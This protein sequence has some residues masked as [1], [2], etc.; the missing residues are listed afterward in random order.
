[1]KKVVIVLAAL[2][3]IGLGAST[4]L[5]IRKSAVELGAAS[6][7]Q[8]AAAAIAALDANDTNATL[9]LLVG[10][11][12]DELAADCDEARA[13]ND[14][15][16]AKRVADGLAQSRPPG[17]VIDHM[18]SDQSDVLHEKGAAI[19][20]HCKARAT[21]V[22]H[23]TTLALHDSAGKAWTAELVAM[24][25]G[26]RWFLAQVPV[27]TPPQAAA[28]LATPDI[29]EPGELTGA[30]AQMWQIAGALRNCAEASVAMTDHIRNMEISIG[31]QRRLGHD[32]YFT[33]ADCIGEIKR[34]TREFPSCKTDN[35]PQPVVA[36]LGMSRNKLMIKAFDALDAKDAAA[37]HA[38]FADAPACANVADVDKRIAD[39]IAASIKTLEFERIRKDE[40]SEACPGVTRHAMKLV[41]HM[42]DGTVYGADMVELQS[43]GRWWLAEL[44]IAKPTP[45]SHPAEFAGKRP[46]ETE[47]VLAESSF[48]PGELSP[49]CAAMWKRALA[50]RSCERVVLAKSVAVDA[51]GFFLKAID[52]AKVSDADCRDA[53]KIY[54]TDFANCR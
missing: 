8:L 53:L 18:G 14:E 6:R 10:P 19:S 54:D 20:P 43:G 40:T 37:L 3:A 51:Y 23:A 47:L 16:R 45:P 13:T 52:H 28:K 39:A 5:L 7:D 17:L 11:A 12:S 44:P 15:A 35:L 31:R 41:F 22:R 21:I 32:P 29:F 48:A 24:E 2:V 36:P 26:G 25:I 9:A 33:D 38:L 30:C 27:A 46:D 50:L 49:S 42:P 1:M 34:W 4:F